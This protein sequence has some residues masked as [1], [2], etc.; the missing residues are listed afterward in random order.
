VSARPG[1]ANPATTTF[2]RVQFLDPRLPA[3]S[4][5]KATQLLAGDDEGSIE[6]KSDLAKRN[7]ALYR[8]VQ[9]LPVDRL[10]DC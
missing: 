4:P 6:A 9:G 1:L 5:P 10:L 3:P 2:S 7:G 8:L